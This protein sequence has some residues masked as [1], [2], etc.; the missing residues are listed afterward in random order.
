MKTEELNNQMIPE[1]ETYCILSYEDKVLSDITFDE[2][3]QEYHGAIKVCGLGDL[4]TVFHQTMWL[5]KLDIRI[6][7]PTDKPEN[8]A[9]LKILASLGVDC[10]LWLDETTPI[11]DENFIDLASYS[12]MSPV[13]HAQIEPFEY[14]ISHINDEKN[15]RPLDL[16]APYETIENVEVAFQTRMNTYYNHFMEL[17]KCSKCKAFRICS[18]CLEKKLSDCEQTMSEILEYVVCGNRLRKED[19]VCQH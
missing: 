3:W 10:G 6:Y 7:L 16:Y 13:P 9:H 4:I 1:V 19:R 18:G 8:Y 11:C 14:I 12:F 2:S 5:Q 15:I 17:D